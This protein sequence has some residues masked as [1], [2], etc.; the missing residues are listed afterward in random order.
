MTT[1]TFDV[2]PTNEELI[3]LAQ[4][5]YA[6]HP[7]VIVS[8]STAG[9]TPFDAMMQAGTSIALVSFAVVAGQLAVS[10]ADNAPAG[11]AEAVTAAVDGEHDGK[12]KTRTRQTD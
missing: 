8:S 4:S 9:L 10:I 3:S 2:N 11:I 1:Q 7:E 5:F 6:A 12:D